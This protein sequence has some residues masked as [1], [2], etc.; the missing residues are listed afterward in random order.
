MIRCEVSKWKGSFQVNSDVS[1]VK[2]MF[3][4]NIDV[5]KST[6]SLMHKGITKLSER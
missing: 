4:V 2:V 3:S 1:K 5:L 6:I